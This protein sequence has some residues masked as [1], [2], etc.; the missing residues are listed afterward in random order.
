MFVDHYPDTNQAQIYIINPDFLQ[1]FVFNLAFDIHINIKHYYCYA[2]SVY[3]ILVYSY[4]NR[5][6]PNDGLDDV[7]LVVVVVCCGVVGYN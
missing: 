6:D 5:V 7:Q 3:I 4:S 1:S 2:Y